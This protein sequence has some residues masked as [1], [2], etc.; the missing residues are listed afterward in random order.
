MKLVRAT[1][2]G[3]AMAVA[4]AACS[5]GP[6]V[7]LESDVAASGSPTPDEPS[8]DLETKPSPT[9]EGPEADER[10]GA[11]A[12]VEALATGRL[13]DIATMTDYTVPGSPA[14][15]YA[16]YMFAARSALQSDGYPAETK[17]VTVSGGTIRT[18]DTTG[19]CFE[20]SD[21]VADDSSRKLVTF[22]ANGE[23]MSELITAGGSVIAVD[24]ATIE[25]QAAYQSPE[26][27]GTLVGLRITAGER[28]LSVN[29]YS[30][31]YVDPDGAQRTATDAYG[32]VE[33]RAGANGWILVGFQDA[34]RG[35]TVYLNGYFGEYDTEWE[36]EIP[37]ASEA[38]A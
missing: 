17:S 31:E 18:C 30:A 33:L 3:L 24:D 12:Y 6:E 15:A 16:A 20:F 36:V 13:P 21:F 22:S 10:A 26:Y 5:S 32:P 19:S 38:A 37:T 9:E 2:W 14:A 29:L 1:M 25:P 34:A 23:P 35:G 11:K 28:P 4:L 27:G 7:A 8:T